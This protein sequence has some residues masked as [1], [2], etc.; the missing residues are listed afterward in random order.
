M[1]KTLKAHMM[2]KKC[3]GVMAKT[4]EQHLKLKKK[5]Y[6]HK[7]DKNCKTKDSATAMKSGPGGKGAKGALDSARMRGDIKE[8]P[9]S[10]DSGL[11]D[12]QKTLPKF[13]QEK[14]QKA[15]AKREAKKEAKNK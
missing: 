11:T 6:D 4:M 5:G 3:K 14:I 12:K 13:L 2:Y 10:S 1:A 8:K 9:Q 7:L 15:K